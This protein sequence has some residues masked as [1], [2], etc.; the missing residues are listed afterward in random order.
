MNKLKYVN[1]KTLKVYTVLNF[2]VMNFTRKD[3]AN[4]MVLYQD[5][6][7]MSFVCEQKEF[8]ERFTMYIE[9]EY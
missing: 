6:N 1:L 9:V 3:Y 5:I 8:K 2:N 7:G 4:V